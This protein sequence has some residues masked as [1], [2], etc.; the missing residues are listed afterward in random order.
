MPWEPPEWCGGGDL[1]VGWAEAPKAIAIVVPAGRPRCAARSCTTSGAASLP[2]V[3]SSVTSPQLPIRAVW[4][5]PS[6]TGEP[7]IAK[8]LTA[9]RP[10]V[11]QMLFAVTAPPKSDTDPTV[12]CALLQPDPVA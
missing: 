1:C 2:T 10:C 6:A 7:L 3:F 9:P 11:A 5:T 12:T 4:P 8:P